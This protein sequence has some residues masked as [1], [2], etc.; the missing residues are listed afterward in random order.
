MAYAVIRIDD[1][2][3]KTVSSM[4]KAGRYVVTSG[5]TDTPTAIENGNIVKFTGKMISG[6]RELHWVTTPA[7][8]D[9]IS[10]IGIVASPEI[11]KDKVG[12][13]N[14]NEFRNEAGADLRIYMLHTG[15]IFTVSNDALDTTV[16]PA[17]GTTSVVLDAATKLQV[18][19][20]SSITTA[21][22]A[23][24]IIETGTWNGV[25]CTTFEVI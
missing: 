16:T 21:V 4:L 6:Q 11:C 1:A 25:A 15:D 12:K 13:Y 17:A 5:N 24:R 10:A 19:T 23:G 2:A 7:A 20:T 14:I 9:S 3:G 18:A 22:V 8:N